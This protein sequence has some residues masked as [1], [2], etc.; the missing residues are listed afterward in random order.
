MFAKKLNVSGNKNL[1]I[2]FFAAQFADAR[3]DDLIFFCQRSES[4]IFIFR[5]VRWHTKKCQCACRLSLG[6]FFMLALTTLIICSF[7]LMQKEPKNQGYDALLTVY[8][9]LFGVRD[10]FAIR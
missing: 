7:A 2:E 8:Y 4:E 5:G 6:I 10:C 1:H 3:P 9:F